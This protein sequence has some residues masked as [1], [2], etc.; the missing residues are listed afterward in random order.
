MSHGMRMR[1]L[2]YPMKSEHAGRLMCGGAT[3]W[4]AL[5]QYNLEA[6]DRVGNIG[7]GGLGH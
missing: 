4:G 5:S 3:V 7:I 1:F 2:I 6:T